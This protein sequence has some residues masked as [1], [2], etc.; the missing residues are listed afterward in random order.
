MS[1][2]GPLAD[3][4]FALPNVRLWHN[5]VEK[6]FQEGGAC[7]LAIDMPIGLPAFGAVG[8]RIFITFL[9]QPVAPRVAVALLASLVCEGF[10]RLR[11]A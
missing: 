1:A 8:A 4:C 5:F 7:A 9:M 6:L 11:P 2:I 3:I 10:A